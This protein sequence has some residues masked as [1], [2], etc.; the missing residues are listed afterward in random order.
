MAFESFTKTGGGGA[1]LQRYA[2]SFSAA[3]C[4]LV[5]VLVAGQQVKAEVPA[6]EDEPVDVKFTEEIPEEK[7]KEEE[8]PPPEPA[9]AAAPLVPAM[10]KTNSLPPPPA[11]EP[12][13]DTIPDKAKE[14]DPSKDPGAFGSGNG[15]PGGTGTGGGGGFKKEVPA[16]PPPPPPPPKPLV[17]TEKPSVGD[18]PAKRKSGALPAYPD[19]LR[20]SGVQGEVVVMLT[21]DENGNVTGAKIVKS[22]PNFDE[23]VMRA[24]LAWKFEPAKHADGTAYVSK[25]Q[26]KIPFHLKG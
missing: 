22:D 14:A 2:I 7:P 1:S 5:G 17:A 21:I 23:V 6:K 16:P 11:V 8:P 20:A 4:V 13:P 18:V 25:K 12:P 24:V 10:V 15:E 3:A 19:A 9:S 26:I